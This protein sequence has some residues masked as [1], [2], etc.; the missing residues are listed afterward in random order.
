MLFPKKPRKT[1]KQIRQE[2]F[3][4]GMERAAQIIEGGHFLHTDSPAYRFA[5]EAAAA[6][7]REKSK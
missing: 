7:R 5:K 2:S 6:I 4:A 3:L 1:V